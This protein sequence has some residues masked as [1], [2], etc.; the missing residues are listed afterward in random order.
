MGKFGNLMLKGTMPASFLEFLKVSPDI[1]IRFSSFT[2]IIISVLHCLFPARWKGESLRRKGTLSFFQVREC[3]VE[4]KGRETLTDEGA[5][6]F[7]ACYIVA[8]P[9]LAKI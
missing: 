4:A 2:N 9:C 5:V 7:A 8:A 1:T 3:S 6:C